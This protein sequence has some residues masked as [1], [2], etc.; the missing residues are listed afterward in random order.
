[1]QMNSQYAK[2]NTTLEVLYNKEEKK[3]NI[4]SI[5]KLENLSMLIQ[6]KLN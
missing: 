6:I 2:V 4:F 3:I 1:M 5:N